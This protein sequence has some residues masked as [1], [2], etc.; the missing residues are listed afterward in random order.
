LNFGKAVLKLFPASG[1]GVVR[2]QVVN[3]SQ[4]R[5]FVEGAGAKFKTQLAP[6]I[7]LYSN[8]YLQAGVLIF[9]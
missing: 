2:S 7:K 6:S 5:P 9:H 3:S 4:E 1:L 8:Y